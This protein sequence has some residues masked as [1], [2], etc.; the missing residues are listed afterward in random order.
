MLGFAIGVANLRMALPFKNQERETDL[1][2]K[3]KVHR[4]SY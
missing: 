4:G 3:A 2:L 1:S